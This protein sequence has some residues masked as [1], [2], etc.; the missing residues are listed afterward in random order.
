MNI[1]I[2]NYRVSKLK[3]ESN[4]AALFKKIGFQHPNFETKPTN[5]LI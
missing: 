1:K 5:I 2:L 4:K 3:I